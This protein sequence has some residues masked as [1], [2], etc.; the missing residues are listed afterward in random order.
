MFF[1]YSNDLYADNLSKGA[2]NMQSMQKAM[3]CIEAIDQSLF[4]ELEQQS[5]QKETEIEAL[6]KGGNRDEAQQQAKEHFKEMMNNVV[7]K[8]LIECR[9]LAEEMIPSLPFENMQEKSKNQHV[10][11]SYKSIITM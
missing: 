2:P 8:K 4:R 6:C 11:V 7:I 10:A 1:N 9:K 3:S 5:K